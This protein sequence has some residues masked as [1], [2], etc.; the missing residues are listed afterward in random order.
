M[1]MF[2]HVRAGK[3]A[4]QTACHHDPI[5]HNHGM[6]DD[7]I[8]IVTN[9]T[10]ETCYDT[11]QSML[12]SYT[13][14]TC[15]TYCMVRWIMQTIEVHLIDAELLS[16]FRTWL[17]CQDIL[18]LHIQLFLLLDQQVSLHNFFCLGYQTLLKSLNLL[19]HLVR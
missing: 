1:F 2:A 8:Y 17:P 4:M 6:H 13:Q 7:Y 16:N 19:N 9:Q 14:T 5:L 18:E 11:T 12:P 15:C 10:F 3:G